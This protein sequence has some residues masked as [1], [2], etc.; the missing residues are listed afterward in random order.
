MAGWAALPYSRD[1]ESTNRAYAALCLRLL[2][3]NACFGAV[4]FS[5]ILF[6]NGVTTTSKNIRNLSA[7]D[8]PHV[9]AAVERAV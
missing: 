8:T 6:C 4:L 1:R 5:A 7:D 3:G 2:V 9:R